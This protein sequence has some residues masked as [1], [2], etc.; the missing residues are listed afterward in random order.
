MKILRG[1]GWQGNLIG[2]AKRFDSFTQNLDGAIRGSKKDRRIL[3]ARTNFLEER[4]EPGHFSIYF[5][6]YVDWL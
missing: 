1:G 6:S 5:I 2:S 3:A 4:V